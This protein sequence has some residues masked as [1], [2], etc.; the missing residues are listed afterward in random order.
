MKTRIHINRQRIA[1]N[2]KYGTKQPV[3]TAKTY[4]DN[5]YGHEVIIKDAKGSEVARITGVD[6]GRK[7]LSCGARVWVETTL[8]VEV[9]E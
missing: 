3:I 2:R 4:K 7:Q 9:I 6:A 1:Q 8:D 5:R